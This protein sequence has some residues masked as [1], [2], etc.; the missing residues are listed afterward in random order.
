MSGSRH[1]LNSMVAIKKGAP[2]DSA[3]LIAS[4]NGFNGTEAEWLSSLQGDPG[5]T[6]T[7]PT[8]HPPS[9]IAQD[10]D[11]RFVTD[12]E[13]VTW[14]AKQ[15]A[16]G[17]TAENSANKVTSITVGS[18]DT[19][20]ASAKLLYD[21]LL[22]KQN[23]EVGKGLS[24]NDFT[25]ALETKLNQMF[26][27]QTEIDFGTTPVEEKD[28]TISNANIVSTSNI[29]VQLA[30]VAPTDKELDEL[31]FDSFDFRSY[32]GTGTFTLHARALEGYVADKF[33]I[34][35]SVCNP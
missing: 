29:I 27:T 30:Y 8:N 17:Y 7:H 33:K 26:I 34:N 9:I 6:Y 18:T 13:K 35:Y 1:P 22:L 21:Q 12:A 31:E 14:N 4:K 25:D 15:N 5:V 19:Q 2:G 20:Y 16:L 24:T 10:T 23:T 3:Y 28:F 11:N 32:A